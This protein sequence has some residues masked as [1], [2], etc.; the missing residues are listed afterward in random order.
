MVWWKF[1]SMSSVKDNVFYWSLSSLSTLY[2]KEDKSDLDSL[3]HL[4]AG[5][6]IK[7]PW[8]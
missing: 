7:A 4:N 1:T 5:A 2:I 3:I 8:H 6:F